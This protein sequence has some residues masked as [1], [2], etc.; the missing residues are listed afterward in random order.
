MKIDKKILFSL[1]LVIVVFFTG[2]SE[3]INH[4][5]DNVKLEKP[6]F[7][8]Y[9]FKSSNP[10]YDLL[11]QI[12]KW[13]SKKPNKVKNPPDW[14]GEDGKAVIIP[15]TMKEISEKRFKENQFNIVA[16]EMIALD[17]SIQDKRAKG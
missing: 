11:K 5:K 13:L 15:P 3:S 9:P 14:P 1:V 16:S 17:R 10:N 7:T 6:L 2:F 8:T 4:N 12:G